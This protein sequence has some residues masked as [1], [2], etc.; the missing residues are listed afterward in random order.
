MVPLARDNGQPPETDKTAN[1]MMT[2]ES[3]PAVDVENSVT[4][5][6]KEILLRT[7]TDMR[8]SVKREYRYGLRV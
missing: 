2:Q 7:E 6:S 8:S 3:G 1:Y 4:T 5:S